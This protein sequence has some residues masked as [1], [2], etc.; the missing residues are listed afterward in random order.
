M[1]QPPPR[2]PRSP[3]ATTHEHLDLEKR[4]V[5]TGLAFH[6]RQAACEGP[7]AKQA[8]Q[9]LLKAVPLASKPL[10]DRRRQMGPFPT[11]CAVLVPNAVRTMAGHGARQD[12][13][14]LLTWQFMAL[15]FH[16]HSPVKN[17][18][19]AC[20]TIYFLPF[21]F[22]KLPIKPAQLEAESCISF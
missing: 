19:E 8:G 7:C 10:N 4:L 2:E 5:F 11:R 9:R 13:R 14:Q 3:R 20:E 16:G 15:T 18:K 1:A 12:Q 6:S 22:F 21:F 17:H